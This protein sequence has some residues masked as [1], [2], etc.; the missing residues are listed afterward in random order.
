MRISEQDLTSLGALRSTQ[1]QQAEKTESRG[2]TGTS[3]GSQGGDKV[4]FSG[5]LRQLAETVSG[6]GS[7]QANRVQE[8]AA[9]YARGAY[10][11]DSSATSQAMVQEALNSNGL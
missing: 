8:L 4:E 10:R 1:T 7:A 5:A 2:V 11:P 6:Y 3:T 9:L